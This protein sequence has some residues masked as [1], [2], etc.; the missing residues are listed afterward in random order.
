MSD[1]VNSTD[2][3][4]RRLSES[5]LLATT[6]LVLAAGLETTVNLMANG[7]ALL[8]K[9]ADQRALL[10]QRPELWPNAIDE[11]LRSETPVQRI[12]RRATRDT[13]IAGVELAQGEIVV[14]MIGA[15]NRDPDVFTDP[16]TFDVTRANA[17]KHLAFGSGIHYCLGAALAKMEAEVG[18][19][20]L[21]DRFPDLRLLDEGERKPTRNLRGFNRL[22]ASLDPTPVH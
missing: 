16:A 3:D 13:R 10:T 8:E 18:F 12:S 21:Y 22:T 7:I 6:M 17:G 11:M 4:G 20:A 5:E 9:H 14:V 1:L 19:R 2:A 15:A